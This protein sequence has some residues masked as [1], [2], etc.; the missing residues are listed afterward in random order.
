MQ[1]FRGLKVWRKSHEL[2]LGIYRT[3]HGF[4]K[5]ERF[6]LTAQLRKSTCSIPTNIAEGCGR[7][8]DADFTRFLQ[9]ALGSAS[10]VEYW[11]L[12]ANDLNLLRSSDYRRLRLA[13]IEVKRMLVALIQTLRS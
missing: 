7:G 2:V 3:T 1:D 4:P 9:V 13:T 12:L 6:G 8:S 5:D 11:L 10:E